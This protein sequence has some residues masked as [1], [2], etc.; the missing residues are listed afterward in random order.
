MC[1]IFS[2]TLPALAADTTF[3]VLEPRSEIQ[4]VRVNKDVSLDIY[5]PESANKQPSETQKSP[6]QS[7]RYPVLYVMDS[8]RYFY[9]ALGYQ[10]TL[11][12][13]ANISPEYIVVGINTSNVAMSRQHFLQTDANQTIK[14]I[15][16]A[17]IPYVDTHYP[18]NEKRAYFGWQFAAMFGLDLFNAAPELFEAYFL[19]SGQHYSEAQLATLEENLKRANTLNLHVYLS[20]GKME[21][22][23]LSGHTTMA[24]MFEKYQPK[25]IRW[26]FSHFDRFSIRYDHHTTPLESLSHGLEWYFS[27]YPDLTFYSLDDIEQ[28]GGVSAVKAYYRKRAKRY[29]VSADVGEQAKFSMFR[30]AAQENNYR[31]F[32]IFEKELGPFEATGWYGFFAQFFFNNQQFERAAQLYQSGLSNRPDDHRYWGGLAQTYESMI[33]HQD[34]L[35]YYRGALTRTKAGSPDATTY[36]QAISRLT[37]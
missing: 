34:A 23:T 18:S 13:G 17:I 33:R 30:H 9:S 32:S 21:T 1:F 24:T 19:A 36:Q 31:L 6:T 4:H 2:F 20:L 11:R 37:K 3:E 27:D 10:K 15:R 16:D 7:K 29:S 22:H 26:K 14:L 28:F 35:K 25:G 8:Q 12:D 5:L